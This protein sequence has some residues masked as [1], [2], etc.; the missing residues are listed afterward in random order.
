MTS[1]GAAFGSLSLADILPRMSELQ[2]G[3]GW[4]ESPSERGAITARGGGRRGQQ[5]RPDALLKGNGGV[6]RSARVCALELSGQ[7]A[8]SVQFSVG[9]RAT[10]PPRYL[11][12]VE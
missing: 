10:V 9:A 5:E 12:I 6:E 7:C 8:R 11:K 3:I 1:P 2:R 4:S